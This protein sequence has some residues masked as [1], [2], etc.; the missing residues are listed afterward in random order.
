MVSTSRPPTPFPHLRTPTSSGGLPVVTVVALTVPNSSQNCCR[1]ELEGGL[2]SWRPGVPFRPRG[3]GE[4]SC[5]RAVWWGPSRP[6]RERKNLRLGSARLS[7]AQPG[8]TA[9]QHSPARASSG[10][11]RQHR[12]RGQA[13][14]RQPAGHSPSAMAPSTRMPDSLTT[15][16]G[17][18]R[19]PLSRGSRWGSSSS[20]KTL[21][22][23]SSAAAEH[24]P[25]TGGEMRRQVQGSPFGRAASLLDLSPRIRDHVGTFTICSE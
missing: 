5:P 12:A 2:A 9:T 17:W 13:L 23:T 22:R 18:K 1:Q 10:V 3:R 15:H 8:P 24:F 14:P 16:S 21:A 19:S 25:G 4:D 6:L 20:R 11:P 7:Q